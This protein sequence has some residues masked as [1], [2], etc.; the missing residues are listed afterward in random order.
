MIGLDGT[1]YSLIRQLTSDGVMPRLAQLIRRSVFRKMT[2]SI[3]E[4]SSVA[5]SSMMTG[6]NP[7]HHGIFGFTELKPQSYH[8]S[9]PNFQ[10]LKVK[11]FWTT[12]NQHGIRTSIINMPSTYPVCA[13]DGLIVSGFISVD[14][15]RSVYPKSLIPRLKEMEYEIDVNAEIAHSDMN[16]FMDHVNTILDR[17]YEFCRWAWEQEPNGCFV[18]VITET[19]RV[20]HFLFPAF[21][22]RSHP[23]HDAVLKFYKRIDSVIGEFID[24][25]SDRDTLIV[26]SD[27]GFCDIRQEVYVNTWLRENGWLK[28]ARVPAESYDDIAQNTLAFALDPCRIYLNRKGIY[29][30]G[31]VDPGD[32]EE[33]LNKLIQQLES[34]TISGETVI[35]KVYRKEQIYTGPMKNAGP[36]LVAVA[37][38]GFDL[39]ASLKK[40][41]LYGR[42]IFTGMHTQD[43]AFLIVAGDNELVPD[44]PDISDVRRIIEGGWKEHREV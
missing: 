5:W 7:G 33:L 18:F 37:N 44:N 21:S 24:R 1:P 28:L 11:P 31:T 43:D 42:S 35:R 9:F 4:I 14:I 23:F 27:H 26:M 17:R 38:N 8:I 36:D 25:L 22:D 41:T 6:T 3:P 39:K 15:N 20:H 16:R 29:P 12:L 13:L 2:S 19:D 30:R 40:D 34:W 32:E 10:H